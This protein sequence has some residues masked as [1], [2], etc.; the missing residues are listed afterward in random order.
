MRFA[1]ARADDLDSDGTRTAFQLVDADTH[2]D[3]ALVIQD[4]PGNLLGHGLDQVDMPFGE[5]RVHGFNEIVVRGHFGDLVVPAGHV[6][7]DSSLDRKTDLLRDALLLGVDTNM[8]IKDQVA[9]ENSIVLAFSN[10]LVQASGKDGHF[11][12]V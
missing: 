1:A 7:R 4:V 9:D 12:H 8:A 11:R 3:D 6:W 2:P 10:A 5:C